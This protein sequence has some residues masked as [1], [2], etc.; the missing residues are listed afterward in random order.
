M[1]AIQ[2]EIVVIG[3]GPGGYSAAFYA[4]DRGK[5]VILVEQNQNLGGVCLNYGCIPSKAFLYATQLIRDAKESK[6]RGI[7]FQEPRIDLSQLNAWKGS[8]VSKLSQGV[9][10][11]AQRRNIQM[12]H[13]TARFEP[14]N[15]LKVETREGDRMIQFHKAIIAVGSR[16]SLPK[17]FDIGS[18]RVMTSTEAL[19]MADIPAELLIVGGGYIGM[20]LGTVY[21][22]L[23][24]RVVVAEALSDILAGADSDMVR[25][26]KNNA[27][28]IFK[29]IRVKTKVLE[30]SLAGEKIKVL[31][32]KDGQ[33]IDELYDK[34]LVSVG[35]M[36]NGDEL[37]LENTKVVR[38]ERGFIE[39]ND[40]QRTAEPS[41]YAIGDVVGGVLL[42]HKAS[43]EARIA[44]DDML[45]ENHSLE[46]YVIPSVVYTDPEI[47]WCGMTENEAK[48]KGMRVE[49]VKFPWAASGRAM[50]HDR[51]DGATKLIVEP[52]TEHILGIGICGHGAG[53][54]IG[55]AVL[56]M[57]MGASARD[58]AQTIHAHPTLSETLMECAEL[59]Y[60]H[61]THAFV[62]KR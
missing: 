45:G 37:G 23:G 61:A 2:T 27:E 33:K 29:E 36:P 40:Q 19:E 6:N 9:T 38:D 8:V 31:M 16:P 28:K 49:V 43:K 41:I 44:V 34:V 51:T 22:T 35:R 58:L 42:A 21:A 60:G 48:Q 4:A 13:G 57:E 24:S 30:M 1:E 7:S 39:V 55:E 10:S 3:A 46:D 50:T 26:V 25:Y 12:I 59:Y 14:D 53:E 56:A 15:L 17:A 5:K 62:R 47:A 32:E 11:L 18:K 20:E 54:L 52:G